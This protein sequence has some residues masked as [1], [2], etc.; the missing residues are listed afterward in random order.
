MW[1]KELNFFEFDSKNWTFLSLTQRI[2]LFFFQKYD[3][4]NWNFFFEYDAKNWTLFENSFDI[5]QRFELI[6]LIWL[7][8][9]NSFFW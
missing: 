8:E 3:S 1:L 5:S 9:L 6:L 4:Q 7:K 2:E